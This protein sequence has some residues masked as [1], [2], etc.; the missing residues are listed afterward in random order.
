MTHS[1]TSP[2][3][4]FVDIDAEREERIRLL[5]QKF[6]EVGLEAAKTDFIKEANANCCVV[7]RVAPRREPQARRVDQPL[8][9]S[10]RL[11]EGQPAY[12]EDMSSSSEGTQVT[13]SMR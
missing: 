11:L 1:M 4:G 6:I 2:S 10:S 5:H 7:K 8:R 9:R 12:K 3:R 13:D